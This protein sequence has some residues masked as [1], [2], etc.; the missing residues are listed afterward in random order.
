MSDTPTSLGVYQAINAVQKKLAS[1]GIDKDQVNQ[2]QKYSFRGIDDVYNTIAPMLAEAGLLILPKLLTHNVEQREGRNGPI[3]YVVVQVEY[4]LVATSD[5]SET[6]IVMPGEAMDSGD[7]ATNKA[8]SAA[9]KY[10][11]FQ[12]FAV[13]TKGDNDADATTHEMVGSVPAPAKAQ[14]PASN[15][16]QPP[17]MDIKTKED[18]AGF[19]AF[20]LEMGQAFHGSS[21]KELRQFWSTNKVQIQYVSENFPD[22]Y[23]ALMKGFKELKESIEK[24]ENNEGAE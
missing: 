5:G 8:M 21:V 15:G 11:I 23:A 4:R 9:Y 13:P 2:A 20:V 10:A 17:R 3:H 12:T 7:K 6:T 18:A 19:V 1:V 22:E 16:P 24:S 14:E